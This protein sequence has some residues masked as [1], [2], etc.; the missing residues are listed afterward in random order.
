M[1]PHL[2]GGTWETLRLARD[3]LGSACFSA[4]VQPTL[5]EGRGGVRGAPLG[6]APPLA[7]DVSR[8]APAPRLLG[9][10]RSPGTERA[11]MSC[12]RLRSLALLGCLLLASYCGR[13]E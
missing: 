11:T 7:R 1:C 10:S 6:A 4:L 9:R 12:G 2:Q 8:R 5:G 3:L 13:G